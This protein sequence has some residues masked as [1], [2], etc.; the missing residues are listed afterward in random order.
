[1][2]VALGFDSSVLSPFARA[3][4]LDVL[5]RITLGRCPF[6]GHSVCCATRC[7]EMSSGSRELAT[8]SMISPSSEE[9]DFHATERDSSDGPSATGCSQRAARTAVNAPGGGDLRRCRRRQPERSSVETR[10][11]DRRHACD[12]ARPRAT[13]DRRPGARHA[14]ADRRRLTPIARLGGRTASTFVT[15]TWARREPPGPVNPRAPDLPSCLRIRRHVGD[16]DARAARRAARAPRRAAR[17]PGSPRE[18]ASPNCPG[19]L[20]S[21]AR[22]RAPSPARRGAARAWL[23]PRRHPHD[24]A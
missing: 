21:R 24:F 1:M 7:T 11:Q 20:R 18:A 19:S 2:A 10:A 15:V 6:A 3:R 9:R 14:L 8:W 5:E 23:C 22:S 4:R 13:S 17:R 12:P 16:P